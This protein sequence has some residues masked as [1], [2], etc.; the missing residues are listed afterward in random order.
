MKSIILDNVTNIDDVIV[1]LYWSYRKTMLGINENGSIS[2]SISSCN[3]YYAHIDLY[4]GYMIHCIDYFDFT[5]EDNYSTYSTY[6]NDLCS[7]LDKIGNYQ[8][9]CQFIGK[10]PHDISYD[11]FK[12]YINFLRCFRGEYNDRILTITPNY[13][14]RIATI[15]FRDEEEHYSYYPHVPNKYNIIIAQYIYVF[16]ELRKKKINPRKYPIIDERYT[17]SHIA[18]L[19]IH[20][21]EQI[22][23]YNRPTCYCSAQYNDHVKKTQNHLLK[24][25]SDE[26]SSSIEDFSEDTQHSSE[27]EDSSEDSSDN[28]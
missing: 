5:K 1:Q 7:K 9:D 8:K 20:I 14:S 3:K 16:T 26:E 11:L 28:V 4:G 17:Y 6:Y 22:L 18:C 25:S 12:K 15:Y 24:D 21:I 10:F 19:P 13:A 27:Q 2:Y 23:Q